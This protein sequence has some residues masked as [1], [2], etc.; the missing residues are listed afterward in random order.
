LVSLPAKK[1]SKEM[2]KIKIQVLPILKERQLSFFLGLLVLILLFTLPLIFSK[3]WIGLLNEILI[4]GLAGMSVNLLLGYGGSLPFGHAALYSTG[5]YTL[6]ILLKKTGISPVLALIISPLAAALAGAIFGLL[7]A[8]LYRFYYAIMTTAFSMVLWTGIRKWV[9]LT[10]GD[11]GT[12]GVE[13]PDILNGINNS[14]FFTLIVFLVSIMMIWFIISSPF[15]WALRAIRENPNR[16]AFTSIDVIK[17]RY[18]AFIISSFFCGVAGALYVVYSHCT[19]PDY[20]Y[21][22]KSGDMVMVC[23][24]GGMSSFFGPIVG[25]AIFI[26][27]QTLITSVTLYMPLVMGIIICAVVLLMP[28]GVMGLWERI[29]PYFLRTDV[30]AQ[31]LAGHGGKKDGLPK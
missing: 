27:L 6:A 9:T 14:Y 2:P 19:F 7:L 4:L 26:L 28:D 29:Q 23:I 20:A 5:A 31:T 24:L 15:G 1:G 21:W 18:L 16:A 3:F 10:G 12:T 11:N 13:F 25:G 8:R 17:H 30:S 22:T